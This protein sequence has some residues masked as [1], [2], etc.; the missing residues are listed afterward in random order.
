MVNVKVSF[1]RTLR[2]PYIYINIY[3]YI[4]IYIDIIMPRVLVV[5][6]DEMDPKIV[7]V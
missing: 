6:E 5:E 7:I 4:Y 1:F 3:I 2:I